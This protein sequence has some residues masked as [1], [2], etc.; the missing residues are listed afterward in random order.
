MAL[1][2][3]SFPRRTYPERCTL[4]SMNVPELLEALQARFP[5]ARM[6]ATDDG[7]IAIDSIDAKLTPEQAALALQNN[8]DLAN[9]GAGDGS[10]RTAAASDVGGEFSK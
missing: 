3:P 5:D 2:F 10:V 4:R 1:I 9:L 6:H 7:H 8:V